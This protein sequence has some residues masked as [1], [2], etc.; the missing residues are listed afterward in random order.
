MEREEYFKRNGW[1][2]E[3]VNRL[4]D[5]GE[6]VGSRLRNR[7]VEVQQQKQFR[8]V[9]QSKFNPRYQKIKIWVLP[10]YLSKEGKGGC[11]KLVARAR[12][13][14]MERWN[15]YWEKEE[16]RNCDLCGEMFGTLEHLVRD[17]RKTERGVTIEEVVSGRKNEKVEEWL[18]KKR[19][20]GS[21]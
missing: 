14:N 19:F 10:E 13:G 5:S 1:S 21:R 18:G 8:K 7:D 6:D 4:R 15:R 16:E 11:Q 9:A 3:G 2:Q 17:C 20:L 12:C